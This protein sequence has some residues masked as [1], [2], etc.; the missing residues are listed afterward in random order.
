MRGKA[1]PFRDVLLKEHS[2]IASRLSF[3]AINERKS[4]SMHAG[5][6]ELYRTLG[7]EAAFAL[8]ASR[9]QFF[10]QPFIHNLRIRFALRSLHYLSDKKPEQRFFA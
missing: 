1:P 5:K 2:L 6:A 9:L 3:E 8:R 4:S 10:A 7:G